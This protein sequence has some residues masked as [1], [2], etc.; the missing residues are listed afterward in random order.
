[1]H[2]LKPSYF[3]C[4][5][6]KGSFN[7]C[8]VI[9]FRRYALTEFNRANPY[10]V[11]FVN[12][13]RLDNA[14]RR[15]DALCTAQ[16]IVCLAILEHFLIAQITRKR[17]RQPG[18]RKNRVHIG[19]FPPMDI[20]LSSF[21]TCFPMITKPSLVQLDLDNVN[22][23]T[24]AINFVVCKPL[25]YHHLFSL[26]PDNGNK[27]VYMDIYPNVAAIATNGINFLILFLAHFEYILYQ[28]VFLTTLL[29]FFQ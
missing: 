6:P 29:L 5:H 11:D 24:L 15:S 20:Y 27:L 7:H 25:D 2:S 13:F 19:N 28:V 8:S 22:D 16:G 10:V 3:S 21:A 1:M 17:S 18:L 9:R 23:D 26:P 4:Q 14:E 12:S